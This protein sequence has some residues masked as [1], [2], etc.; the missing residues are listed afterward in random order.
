MKL[1]SNLANG[2]RV[3]II[4][5]DLREESILV[6]PAFKGFEISREK[7]VEGQ[8]IKTYWTLSRKAA[9][10]PISKILYKTYF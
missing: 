3:R 7:I 9:T 1:A 2:T 5:R 4:H 6:D 8:D 10:N